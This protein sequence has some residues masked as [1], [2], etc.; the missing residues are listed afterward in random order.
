MSEMDAILARHNAAAANHNNNNLGGGNKGSRSRSHMRQNSV[1]LY[2]KSFKGEVQPKGQFKD[3]LFGI[4][5]ILQLVLMCIVGLKFGPDAL[6]PTS[7]DLGLEEGLGD[8]DTELDNIIGG[9]DGDVENEDDTKIVLAYQNIVKMAY[10]CGAFAIIVSALALAFMMAM[11]RRLVYVALVLS[12]GVSFAW[13]TIGI[14]ISPKSFVPITGIIALMLTVGYMFVVWDRIP[15]ASANLT[16]ALTGVRDNLGL[17]GVAFLFQF[18]AL[19]CSIYYTFTFVGLHDAMHAGALK[20]I[21]DN[22]MIVLDALLLVSYY[23]TYQVLR[24]RVAQMY[25]LVLLCFSPHYSFT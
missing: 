4:L 6:V 22:A 8:D 9:F 7:E 11:S 15:F 5:F 24:V 13:G 21:S 19:V 10:T 1:N 3:V 17:V 14:G 2:M 16:T 25:I 18:L 12:I 23:W 20:G